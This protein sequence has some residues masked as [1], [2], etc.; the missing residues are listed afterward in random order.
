MKGEFQTEI[1]VDPAKFSRLQGALV[2]SKTG[3][4]EGREVLDL[5]LDSSASEIDI[6][7]CKL[8]EGE[9]QLPIARLVKHSRS[10]TEK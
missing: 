2:A 6:I 8:N 1:G 3:Y 4:A 9:D 10:T 7:L 5:Y